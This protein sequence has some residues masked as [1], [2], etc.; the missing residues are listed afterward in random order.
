MLLIIKSREEGDLSLFNK[1][2]H[3]IYLHHSKGGMGFR[4]NIFM[5]AKQGWRILQKPDSLLAIF[6]KARYFPHTP[7]LEADIG[8]NPSHA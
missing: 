1:A 6:F 5:A 4:I 3:L 8:H 2:F 7:F